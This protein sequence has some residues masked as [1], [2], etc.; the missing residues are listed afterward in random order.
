MNSGSYSASEL[1]TQQDSS[2][3]EQLSEFQRGR[4]IGMKEAGSAN[5]RIADH[6]GRSDAAIRKYWQERVD[7]STFRRHDG[8]G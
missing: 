5:R 8:S 7:N 3:Y 4:I 6:M 1:R 2:S